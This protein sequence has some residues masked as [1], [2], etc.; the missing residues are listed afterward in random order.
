MLNLIQKLRAGTD[1]SD[2][3]FIKEVLDQE[4]TQSEHRDYILE[5]YLFPDTYEFYITSDT[6]QVVEKM[7][8]RFAEIY[9][10]DL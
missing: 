7:L 8:N 3:S 1:Y 5:G 6:D 9:T 2:Y 4:A 10:E